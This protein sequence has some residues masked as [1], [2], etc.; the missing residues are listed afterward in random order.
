MSIALALLSALAFGAGMTLQQRGARTI[1]FEHALRASMLRRLLTRKVWLAGIAVSG[2]GF[3]A[4]LLALRTGALV[5]VQ[6]IVTS[7]LV[8]CLAITA[9]Y[10]REPL[11]GR[12]WGAITAVVAGVAVFLLAGT[13]HQ[14]ATAALS[15]PALGAASLAFA[16][17]TAIC[18]RHART[19][20]GLARAV[21]VGAAA[22]LGNAYVAVLG[23][24]AA[25]ALHH[26]VG[27]L[28]RSPYPYALG[29]AAVITVLLVQAIYQAGRPTLSL[30]IAT[31]T[32][33]VGSLVLA[34]TVLHERPVLTGLRGGMAILAFGI[35]LL[36]LV[37]LSRDEGRTAVEVDQ[38][39]TAMG[40]T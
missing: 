9:W 26:G 40:S 17:L 28:L 32:E 2:V 36:G 23:R 35:A 33:A 29:A 27:A 31:M 16:G 21:A 8:V 11:G 4:Q 6:P 13:A 3:L 34:I 24:A 22:G 15:T 5:V 14:G 25:D 37:D 1:P 38:D 19:G 39:L 20:A 12:S 10:D 7:A 30:P 18:A